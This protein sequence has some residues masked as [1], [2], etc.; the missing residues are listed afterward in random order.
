M[1]CEYHWHVYVIKIACV[2][3]YDFY[4]IFISKK[5]SVLGILNPFKITTCEEKNFSEKTLAS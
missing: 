3:V 5:F 4:F 2:C 1:S